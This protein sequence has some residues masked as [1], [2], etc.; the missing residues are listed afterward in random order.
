MRLLLCLLVALIGE[1]NNSEHLVSL[2]GARST[3]MELI[4]RSLTDHVHHRLD[5][6]G[7]ASLNLDERLLDLT[8]YK[9]LYEQILLSILG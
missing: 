2:V 6:G 1:A 8:Q 7:R 3:D 9:L 4:G 5:F